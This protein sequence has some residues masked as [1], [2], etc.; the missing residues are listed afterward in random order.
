MAFSGLATDNARRLAEARAQAEQARLLAEQQ[1]QQLEKQAGELTER[2]AAQQRLL[3]LV[4]EL[5][6]PA[7]QLA[8]G[9]L[10]VPIVGHL[11]SPH[12]RIEDCGFASLIVNQ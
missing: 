10:F 4:A 8:D 7:V 1:A 2:N 5:E 3:D 11:D 12:P 6:T 9:V